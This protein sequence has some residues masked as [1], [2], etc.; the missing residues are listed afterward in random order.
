MVALTL[1]PAIDLKGGQVVEDGTFAELRARG[2]LFAELWRMQAD[3]AG[4]PAQLRP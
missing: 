4:A 1:F 3:P 2:G